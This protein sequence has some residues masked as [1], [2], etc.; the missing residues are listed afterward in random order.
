[1]RRGSFAW[2]VGLALILAG[3]SSGSFLG[4]RLDNFTA[5]Y[6]T[7][8]NA[9]RT[10]G[11]GVVALRTATPSIDR[12][13][14]LSVYPVPEGRAQQAKFE[15]AI[16]KSA[17]VL[18]KHPNSKW[19]D[20]ALMLIGQAYFY[21]GQYVAAEQKFR[22]IL[23]ELPAQNDG[24]PTPLD[25]EARLW[26]A[27]TL[28]A[29]GRTQAATD[30]LAENLARTD[31]RASTLA[32]LHLVRADFAVGKGEWDQ[33]ADDLRA[34]LD[35]L[36]GDDP[37]LEARAAFLLGQV[38]ETRAHPTEAVAAYRRAA[39]AAPDFEMAYAADVSTL[40]LQ[41]A[42]GSAAPAL[43]ELRRLTRD[44]KYDDRRAE[45]ALVQA[46]V[47]AS[48]GDLDASVRAYGDALYGGYRDV[49]TTRGRA[50]Y[51]LADLYRT[52]YRD[53]RAAAVYYD[54]AAA[55]LQGAVPGSGGVR[56]TS[57]AI[58]DAA[59]RKTSFGAYAQVRQ[60]IEDADSLLRVGALDEQAFEAFVLQLRQRRARE[61]AEAERE[62]RRREDQARFSGGIQTIQEGVQ[63]TG[64]PGTLPTNP[65]TQPAGGSGEGFM[66]YL[67]PT[68]VRENRLAFFQQWGERPLVDHWRRRS[69]ITGEGAVALASSVGRG[70][71]T[72][73][74]N[75][76]LP[77]VDLSAIPR[78]AAQR[79]TLRAKRAE[80]RYRL[81]NVYFLSL[82]QPDSAAVYFRRVLVDD[83]TAQVVP[84]ALFALAEAQAALGD[85]TSA[86]RL[87]EEALARYSDHDF[88]DRLRERLGLAPTIRTD[89][90]ALAQAAYAAARAAW[91][92]DAPDAFAR[93]IDLAG[94]Y[95]G[96]PVAAQAL[97][98]AAL[99]FQQKHSGD[100]LALRTMPLPAE[101]GK[102]SLAGVVPLPTPTDSTGALLAQSDSVRTASAGP[103]VLVLADL[104]RT[105]TQLYA[106]TP[107]GAQAQLILTALGQ[108]A[109]PAPTAPA[110]PS[111]PPGTVPA[112][113]P[114]RQRFPNSR[115]N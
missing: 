29:A 100:S 16:K 110:P 114:L 7:F 104:L 43:A 23:V 54:S 66:F 63:T 1:M 65:G 12:T 83:S 18:R 46:Q 25:R 88:A 51:G 48:S 78:T 94:Q 21:T 32:R 86:H 81:G 5:Y 11:E 14:Y 35:G 109:A 42:Q 103:P 95:R 112:D 26:M 87:Y 22:E 34:G 68:R 99:A 56:T 19:S 71:G 60:E 70:D 74:T 49:S 44:S 31:L 92:E 8:Y 62:R 82:N 91:D 58:L 17:D 77:S 61:L 98:G 80:A 55:V 52:Q 111:A 90:T 39:G 73:L 67:N 89:S 107:Y 45:L 59:E 47:L 106:D 24:K 105:L 9:R 96:T 108:P 15:N 113:S 36:R 102:L 4:Q 97:L 115:D 57:Q 93:L 101:T 27:R 64:R 3:C 37:D 13:R 76:G 20:D 38:E 50:L 75:D 33:A 41:A 72:G 2:S 10:F 30:F 40:R 6:N 28:V 84:Q 69:A 79:D 85:S 53:Y